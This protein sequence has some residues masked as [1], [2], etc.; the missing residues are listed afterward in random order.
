MVKPSR[1]FDSIMRLRKH[2]LKFRATN[3]GIQDVEVEMLET[4]EGQRSEP[5]I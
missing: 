1:A 3:Q 4:K 2:K 5:N